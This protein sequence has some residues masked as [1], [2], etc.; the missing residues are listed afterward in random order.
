MRGLSELVRDQ[1]A[2]FFSELDP[3]VPFDPAQAKLVPDASPGFRTTRLWIEAMLRK[4]PVP[5]HQQGLSVAHTM[6]LDPLAY[7]RRAVAKALDRA[8]LRP[9]LLIAD[10]V[11]LGKTL[12]IG[13]ILA[14]L[15]RRGRA[16]SIL[17]VTPRH[18]LEQ[19]QRELWTRFA[20]PLVRLDSRGIQRVRRT[21]PA[22]RNPFTYFPRVIVSIDTLKSDAY[23]SHLRRREW[24]VVVVDESHNVTNTGT[25]NHALVEVLARQCEAL[26]L[27]SATPHNG[28]PESFATLVDLLDPTAIVD[29]SDYE[30][31]DIQ[32]L[33]VRRHRHSSD[34]AAEVGHLWAER[35]E[36][37][38]LSV[39]MTPEEEAVV[40]ELWTTWLGPARTQRASALLAWGFAK[41]FLSSPQALRE[42]VVN[43][44]TPDR[45]DGREVRRSP[46]EEAVLRRL[47]ALTD[48]AI[49]QG[50]SKLDALVEQLG[51][52]GVGRGEPTRVVCFTERL[53]TLRWLR[54]ELPAR[55]GM[56]E[57]AFA[58]LH[59]KLPDEEQQDVVEQF[60]LEGSPLRVLLTGDV[61][62]EGVN[63]HRQCHHLVHVDIPWSL[64]RIEQRNGRIDRYGQR[65][66]PQISAL[67]GLTAHPEFSAD[68]RVLSRLLAK[69]HAAHR[70]LGDAAGLMRLHDADREEEAILRAL[71]ERRDLDDVVPDPRADGTTSDQETG[72][73]VGWSFEELFADLGERPAEEPETIEPLGFFTRDLDYLREALA[74]V[75]PDGAT[76]WREFPDEGLA[77]LVPPPDL[78]RRLDVLPQDYVA[79]R[80]V[81]RRLV[82][83]TTRAAGERSLADA[84]RTGSTSLWPE[85]H[86]LSPLH[87]VLEWVT[88]RALARLGRGE[89]PAVLADVEHPMVIMQGVMH[90]Q[91]GQVLLHTVVAL[92]F[93][94]GEGVPPVVQDDGVGVL[95]RSGIAPGAVN[96]GRPF[97]AAAWGW[98]VPAAVA[99]MHEH[100]EFVGRERVAQVREPLVEQS[101]RIR[102]WRQETAARAAGLPAHRRERELARVERHG[103]L[104]QDL[105]QAMTTNREP[106]VRPLAVLLPQGVGS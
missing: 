68:V 24:D 101:L 94:G 4:T 34:V 71:A 53:A 72:D 13:M 23:R 70:A 9:R 67:V 79:E 41:A 104:A 15:A 14:E 93:V 26:L 7:Q 66:A 69:E 102:R 17:V 75:D 97:D 2:T 32:R 90:D 44:L 49:A 96:P 80:G 50:P 88:D 29:P 99:A 85:A 1:A 47:L 63:L 11:G 60:G 78:V 48:A 55:L 74:E 84:R 40:E 20:I 91:R 30:V 95:T 64:I 83:A 92:R 103:A 87:P 3:P 25:K 33:F 6:L 73:D 16:E 82:L 52:I 28:R 62:S 8:N 54:Q 43:R 27:A 35:P 86:Y 76:S 89:V 42:S 31:A 22:T 36:P 61:A 21:L 65:H 10:A 105:A 37:S 38:M 51:A 98:L 39:A 46:E 5:L 58:V 45:R 12:E 19:M 59:G 100:L 18:V 77:E 81:R 57:A 106:L 56:P